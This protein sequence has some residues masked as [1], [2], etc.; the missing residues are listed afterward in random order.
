MTQV[1]QTQT[2]MVAAQTRAISA[3]SLPPVPTY[4]GEGE[5]SLEDGFERWIEQF[6]E[7]SEDLRRYHLKIRLS[8]TSFQTYWLLPEDV[9]AIVTVLV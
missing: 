9:K 1:V 6:E 4:S 5:Q 2:A 3:E 8:K 7:W